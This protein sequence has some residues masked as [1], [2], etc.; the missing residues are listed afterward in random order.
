MRNLLATSLVLSLAFAGPSLAET[1]EV[2]MLNKGEEGPMVFEPS[3]LRIAAGDTVK[4]IATDKSHN[5][6]SVD[7]LMPDG[8]KA[9]KGKI[10]EEIEVTFETEGFYGIRCKPHYAMGMVMVIAVG[11]SSMDAE[12]FLQGR[13]PKRARERFEAQLDAL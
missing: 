12:T 6:E 2:K 13:I 9:F 11:D 8:A 3:S 5:A 4:F 7:E 1:F 10:N